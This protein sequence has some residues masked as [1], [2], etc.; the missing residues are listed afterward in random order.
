MTFSSRWQNWTPENQ[1]DLTKS[2]DK[3]AKSLKEKD[4]FSQIPKSSTDKTAKSPER[5]FCQLC[6]LVMKAYLKI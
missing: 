3:T 2:I 5:I 6:Q 4:D 1:G